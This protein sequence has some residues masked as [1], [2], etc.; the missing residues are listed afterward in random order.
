MSAS[1]GRYSV[2]PV[3]RTITFQRDRS[4]VPNLDDK[5]GVDPYELKGDELSW[6]VAPR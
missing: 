2:D 6:K 1:F 4:S 3:K 5:T